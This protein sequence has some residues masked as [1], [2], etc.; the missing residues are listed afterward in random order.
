MVCGV[1]GYEGGRVRG[2]EGMRE[3]KREGG[4]GGREGTLN[5]Y[6]ERAMKQ[7]TCWQSEVLAL[8]RQALIRVRRQAIKKK[9]M[10]LHEALS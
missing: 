10:L 2:R 8:P 9:E 4:K 5:R 1:E 7:I 6:E 3:G